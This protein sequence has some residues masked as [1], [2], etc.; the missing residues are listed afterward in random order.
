MMRQSLSLMRYVRQWNR[1]RERQKTERECE[2]K[3]EELR[4]KI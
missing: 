3:V 2:S 1:L 4:K